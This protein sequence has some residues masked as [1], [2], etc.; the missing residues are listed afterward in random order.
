MVAFSVALVLDLAL[1]FGAFFVLNRRPKGTPLTWGEAFV[2]ATYVWAILLLTY[3]VV[4][5]QFITMCD[6]DLRWRS[7][8]FGI[9]TGPF[10]AL[11]GI[12]RHL[13]WAK[14]VTF[15]GHGRLQV[16]EDTIRDMIVSG[17]YVVGLVAHGTLWVKVQNR[18]KQTAEVVPVSPYGRP[19]VRKA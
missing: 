6:K 2:G 13:L 4:P 15:M 19:L 8:T 9:P 14:G 12:H 18:G 16:N 5:H 7:D 3:A 11:P 17:I 1:I 10:Y